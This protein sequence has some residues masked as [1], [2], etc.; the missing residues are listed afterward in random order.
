MPPTR[1]ETAAAVKA[2]MA[3]A[4]S[5]RAAGEIPAGHLQALDQYLSG[6]SLG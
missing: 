3:V 5:I 2:L 4:E 6:L 1:T